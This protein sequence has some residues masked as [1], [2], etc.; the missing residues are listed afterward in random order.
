[1]HK[2]TVGIVGASGYSGVEAARILAFHDHVELKFATSDRWQGDTLGKRLGL[3]GPLGQL[4]FAPLE[5]SGV[6]ARSCDVVFLATPAEVSFELVPP[7]VEAGVRVIDLSGAFRLK[8][9]QAYPKAYGRAH[10]APKLLSQAV[11]GLPELFGPKLKGAR[12]IAN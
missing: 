4:I 12:L 3:G 10:P 7:L 9:A 11:Y 1:M 5:Q 6:L 2:T 8:D